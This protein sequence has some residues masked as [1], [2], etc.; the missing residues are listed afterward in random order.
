MCPPLAI[1]R[2]LRS[3]GDDVA[4]VDPDAVE[5]PPNQAGA[6]VSEVN[7]GRGNG[8][9]Q[10]QVRHAIAIHI[11]DV[12]LSVLL[13]AGTFPWGAAVAE[14]DRRWVHRGGVEAARRCRRSAE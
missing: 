7:A 1:Q 6:N 8:E 12:T 4:A 11:F 3:S 13:G 14:A 10:E 2:L 9:V 5:C